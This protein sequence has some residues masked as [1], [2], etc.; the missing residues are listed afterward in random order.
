MAKNISISLKTHPLVASLNRPNV[1]AVALQCLHHISSEDSCLRM[2][3]AFIGTHVDLQNTHSEMPN[4]KDK[5][6]HIQSSQKC[7]QK[8]CKK[9]MI[10][11]G[12][13]LRQVTFHINAIEPKRQDYQKTTTQSLGHYHIFEKGVFGTTDDLNSSYIIYNNIP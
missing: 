2:I 12:G 5:Q 3:L 1:G 6:L 13:S 9:F 11:L 7:S 10:V 4:E 8:R